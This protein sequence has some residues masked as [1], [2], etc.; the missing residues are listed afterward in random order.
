MTQPPAAVPGPDLAA[1][2]GL[3]ADRTRAAMCLALLDGRAWTATE[4]ARLAG[5][6]PSTATGH[7]H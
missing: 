3:L 6:A 7:L 5:V 1:L 2:A 4:L